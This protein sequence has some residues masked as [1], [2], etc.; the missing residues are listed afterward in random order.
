MV[1]KNQ[2]ILIAG[3]GTGGHLFPAISIGEELEKSGM[4]V[5]Y[6]GSKYGIEKKIYEE[7]NLKYFLLNITGIK[8]D[9]SL[10]SILKN[11]L[12][13]I[14]F[15][16][17]Y[18]QTLKLILRYKPKAIIGTGGYCSGVPLILGI[19]FK[20]PTFI[21]DQNSVPGLITKILVNKISKIFVGF[22][23]LQ[24]L[25]DRCIYTG[26]PI[27]KELIIKSKNDAKE[28][29]N[30][31]K[32]KKL[33]FIVGGSQ[34]AKPINVH[35]LNNIN[36]YIENDYQI[37]WQSGS[38]DYELLNSNIHH[39]NIKIKSFINN[40]SVPYSAADIV[41]SRAGALA[42][43]ELTFMG[44]AMILIP[45]PQAAE[46]HQFINAKNIELHGACRIIKQHNLPSGELESCIKKLL[47]NKKALQSLE[48]KSKFISKP[49]A[50]KTISNEVLRY[51]S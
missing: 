24:S 37:I 50:S 39:K 12:L 22:E 4:K 9:Y 18:L 1:N 14:N 10:I 43:S 40:I 20:I 21:Q 30:F 35:I 47:N 34:G 46:N 51:I 6:I 8:R 2:I 36:F 26:N 5:Y 25:N 38:Y 31:D 42:I 48:N 7:N 13:P 49:N 23:K 17:S 16:I 41:V 15:I 33:I 11:L 29:M 32:N 45:F 27:R 44:K 28:E 19:N 3:G